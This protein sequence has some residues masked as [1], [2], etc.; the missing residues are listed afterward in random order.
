[1]FIFKCHLRDNVFSFR[2]EPKMMTI[3]SKN[4]CFLFIILLLF[5]GKSLNFDTTSTF[6]YFVI[7]KSDIPL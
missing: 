3:I 2:G 6:F 1:M 5:L 7:L 4:E